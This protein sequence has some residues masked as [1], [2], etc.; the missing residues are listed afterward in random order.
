MSLNRHRLSTPPTEG[1]DYV[2]RSELTGF[3]LVAESANRRDARR[4]GRVV[5]DLG[6]E[7]LDVYVERLGV[8]HVVRA[9]HAVDD[10]FTRQHATDVRHQQFEQLELFQW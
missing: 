7:S 5:F 6:P 9:P 10:D 2:N 3:E 4:L 1:G 8:A